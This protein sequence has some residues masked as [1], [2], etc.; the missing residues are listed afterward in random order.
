MGASAPEAP[1]RPPNLP[2]AF[3]RL[4]F[5]CLALPD[6]NAY[7]HRSRQV[8]VEISNGS[9]ALSQSPFRDPPTLQNESCT[10]NSRYLLSTKIVKLVLYFF[11]EAHKFPAQVLNLCI[12]LATRSGFLNVVLSS[13][14]LVFNVVS[15]TPAVLDSVR[16]KDGTMPLLKILS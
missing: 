3:P 12:C 15:D 7:N 6:R 13:M 16:F 14:C 10:A 9:Q 5:F 8:G 1:S 4:A 2:P 11:E